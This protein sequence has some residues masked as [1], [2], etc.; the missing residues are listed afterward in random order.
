MS[1]PNSLD[2][3][4]NEWQN[5][6]TFRTEFKSN[7]EQALKNAGMSLTAPDLEKIQSMLKLKTQKHQD[8][9]LDKKINK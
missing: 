7:P 1:Q 6:A 4:Y 8:E 3:V 2:D 5:N 9:S